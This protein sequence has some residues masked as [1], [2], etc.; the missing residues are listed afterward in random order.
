MPDEPTTA[1]YGDP[2]RQV[3]GAKSSGAPCTSREQMP[4]ILLVV[5]LDHCGTRDDAAQSMI[6][7]VYRRHI[8]PNHSPLDTLYPALHAS[9]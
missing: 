9:R 5:A 7:S 8:T 1:W 3:T 2:R 4:R 6:T